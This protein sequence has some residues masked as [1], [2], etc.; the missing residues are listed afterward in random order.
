M[1]TVMQS[2]SERNNVELQM[3]VKKDVRKLCQE[4]NKWS[5]IVSAC[6]VNNSDGVY[7]CVLCL[8]KNSYAEYIYFD[9]NQLHETNYV[10]IKESKHSENNKIT[11]DSLPIQYVHIK[12]TS[13]SLPR[14]NF[15]TQDVHLQYNSFIK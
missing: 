8:C 7:N 15:P 2:A 13:H 5:S 14:C 6:P 11:L 4:Y 10:L 3:C 1:V 12:S 9:S